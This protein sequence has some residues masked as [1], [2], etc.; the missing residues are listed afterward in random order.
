[1]SYNDVLTALADDT[2]C[3]KIEAATV[4]AAMDNVDSN[5]SRERRGFASQVLM[6]SVPQGFIRAVI[7]KLDEAGALST[8]T[9]SEIDSAVV[10]AFV[11][12]ND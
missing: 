1:M 11:A 3:A 9:D 12:I 10:A 8:A 6:S 5:S 4:R 7:L 2:T